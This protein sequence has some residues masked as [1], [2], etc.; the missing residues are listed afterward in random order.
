[1]IGSRGGASTGT[2]V[3]ATTT[4]T[5]ISTAGITVAT[6][7]ATK[8]ATAVDG[9]LGRATKVATAVD[10]SLGRATKAATV[11]AT[12]VVRSRGSRGS[13]RSSSRAQGPES[14]PGRDF[15]LSDRKIDQNPR[16][17]VTAWH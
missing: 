13:G 16:K 9:S 7:G 14:A 3:P 17:C 4:I 12:V 1:M 15:A 11:V 10:G 2:G 5:A 6:G 8:V